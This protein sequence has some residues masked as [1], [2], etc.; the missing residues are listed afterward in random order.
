VLHPISSRSKGVYPISYDG[1]DLEDILE[2][3]L[4]RVK[5]LPCRYLG[6]PL[7]LKKMRRVDYVHFLDKVGSKIPRWK[8]KLMNKAARAQLVKTVLTFIVTYHATVLAPK[9]VNKEN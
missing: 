6:L 7:H 2:G 5:S 1:I 4:A 3:F 9:M 8:V